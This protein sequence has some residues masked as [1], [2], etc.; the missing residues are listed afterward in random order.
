[1]FKKKGY[2]T[3]DLFVRNNGQVTVD[4]MQ[5][6]LLMSDGTGIANL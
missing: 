6:G 4:L 3:F 1:M 2:V 5:V